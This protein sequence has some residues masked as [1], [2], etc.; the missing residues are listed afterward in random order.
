MSTITGMSRDFIDDDLVDGMRLLI[1]T[2]PRTVVHDTN[3]KT[4]DSKSHVAPFRW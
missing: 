1:D 4:A 2:V 3:E